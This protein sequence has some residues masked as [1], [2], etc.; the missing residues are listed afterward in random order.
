MKSFYKKSVDSYIES[1]E[2]KASI[3]PTTLRAPPEMRQYLENRIRCAYAEGW[4]AA[5]A[6]YHNEHSPE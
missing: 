3:D 2:G 5:A 6:R 1:D 4:N